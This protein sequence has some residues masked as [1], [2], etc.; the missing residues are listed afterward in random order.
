MEIIEKLENSQ[1]LDYE[2]GLKLYELDLFTLGKYA[3]KIREKFN[4]KKV[5]FNVN[6]HINP[7]NFCED[8]CLFC[9]FSSHRKNDKAYT[10]T[11]EEI[12][13]I[14]E[15]A[16]K[17]GIKE[18]HI[19]SSHNPNV[20]WQWY[21]EIFKL[22][23]TKYPDL[24]IKAMTAAEVDYLHRKDGFSYDEIL[25]KMI[26]Y[27]VDSMPGGGA[28]IFD[29]ELRNKIC[30][31]KVNSENWLKIHEIWHNLGRKSTATMLFGHIEER[32][33][34]IKHM[35]K[36]R[37]LQD[38]TGGF[39]VF[40]PLVFQ[41]DNNFL[42]DIKDLGAQEILKTY[43]ISRIMLDNFKHIKAYWATAGLNLAI[44]AQEFGCDDLDGTIENESIQSSAG[45]KSKNG[46]SKD[47]FIDLIK[48]SNFIPV[49][50]D[51]LY[52]EI[53]IY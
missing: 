13:D 45:A 48:T 17:R 11:H 10:M 16:V 26:E 43:A 51:S 12:L 5:Y 42:K 46:V 38:K 18:V 2:D 4:G 1:R 52:N 29:E 28:E 49:Q 34:R 14:V 27:G 7:T 21:L 3:S 44:L 37:E 31:T 6:R 33:H 25:Q 30:P 36:L 20:T 53:E 35:I 50:R 41:R 23:K 22:I 39:Q 24:H 8:V 19:V 47:E 15:N 32:K 40:I 9:A